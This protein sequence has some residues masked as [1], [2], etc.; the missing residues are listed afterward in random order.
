MTAVAA[1]FADAQQPDNDRPILSVRNLRAHFRTSHF[2]IN[3]YVKAVDGI[4]FDVKRG[5]IYGLAGESSSGKT[6]LIKTIA[7]IAPAYSGQLLAGL[8]WAAVLTGVSIEGDLFESWMKRLAGLKDSGAL[9]PGH[10]GLLDR[11]DALCSTV[12]LAALYFAYP[13]LRG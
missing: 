5:E 13:V 2:G 8:I 1:S 11:V 7:A 10:G 9:L 12:P 6:T 3:R 4:T